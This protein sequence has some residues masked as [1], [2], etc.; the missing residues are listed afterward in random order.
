MRGKWVT[1]GFLG[2]LLLVVGTIFWIGASG[3][4]TS[5]TRGRSPFPAAPR[6]SS[7]A[8]PGST[9]PQRAAADGGSAL[10]KT[11]V[12]RAVRDRMRQ[13]IF[14]AWASADRT[15]AAQAARN[16]HEAIATLPDGGIDPT[17]VRERIREDF[18]PMAVHCYEALLAKDSKAAGKITV[19]FTIVGDEKV[20]G[21]VD[22]ATVAQT[23]L[24]DEAFQTCMRETMMSMAFRP[25]PQGG[26]VSVS[27]PFE[28]SPD[29]PPADAGPR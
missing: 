5:N 8:D 25:P 19:D 1:L 18:V 15:P 12:D 27:Y 7:T 16:A 3:G 21:V 22:T 20:G 29:E 14:A 17:Y 9:M 23:T 10:G 24:K 2:A 4:G 13:Q 11:V 26:S 6:A 28:L